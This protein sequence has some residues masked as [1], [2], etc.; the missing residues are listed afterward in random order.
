[1]PYVYHAF[2][3]IIAGG[4]YD[5][6]FYTAAIMDLADFACGVGHDGM[7]DVIGK[8]DYTVEVAGDLV[9]AGG[10]Q[11]LVN[12]FR[13]YRMVRHWLPAWPP[14]LA[15]QRPAPSRRAA[16]TTRVCVAPALW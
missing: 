4:P 6:G 3:A 15:R 2:F 11:K 7:K 1:M 9:Y 13:D 14:R 8:H 12:L 5:I 16:R 10:D